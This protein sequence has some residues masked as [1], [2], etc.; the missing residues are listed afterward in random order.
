MAKFEIVNDVPPPRENPIR[1]KFEVDDDGKAITA[2][3]VD[4]N[5]YWKSQGFLFKIS[6]RGLL[7]YDSIDRSL[8]IALDQEGHLAVE[9]D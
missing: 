8:G 4:E 6:E 5:G 2:V 9:R 7:L 1:I 3:V